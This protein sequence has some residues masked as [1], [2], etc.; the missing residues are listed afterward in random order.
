MATAPIRPKA[1]ANW[2]TEVTATTP[3]LADARRHALGFGGGGLS[4][5]RKQWF[6]PTLAKAAVVALAADWVVHEN[7]AFTW[8]MRGCGAVPA[9][10]AFC[11]T[12]AA[13][14]RS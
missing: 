5:P 2:L 9:P 11:C 3:A 10:S 14:P 6:R 12:H 13:G 4:P 1:Y 8:R 7:E